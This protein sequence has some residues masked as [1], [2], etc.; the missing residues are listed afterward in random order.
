MKAKHCGRRCAFTSSTWP[1]EKR[2]GPVMSN[3]HTTFA[4]GDR[5]TLLALAARAARRRITYAELIA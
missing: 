4:L 5:E 3:N 1:K 2:E